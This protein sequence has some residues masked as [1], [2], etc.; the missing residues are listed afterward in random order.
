MEWFYVLTLFLSLAAGLLALAAVLAARSESPRLPPLKRMTIPAA[1]AS[2]VVLIISAAVH[3][4][5]EHAPGSPHA[6][7]P[8]DFF[9]HHPSFLWVGLIPT[10]A[11]VLN[12]FAKRPTSQQ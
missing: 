3:L 2:W 1:L 7:S 11:L 4:G 6:L 9:R 5:W 8:I 12:Y 10:V